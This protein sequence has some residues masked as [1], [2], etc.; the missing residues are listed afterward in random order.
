MEENR[1]KFI[2]SFVQEIGTHLVSK[3]H[4][5]MMVLGKGEGRIIGYLGSHSETVTPG[6][7]SE[8]LN[9]GSGRIANAL[10]NLET[11]KLVIRKTDSLDK[12]RTIVQLTEKGNDSFQCVKN[13]MTERIGQI[14]D[15]L[16][17]ED[18]LSLL[19]LLRKMN[20][21]QGKE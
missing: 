15:K 9:V 17:E 13:E 16:G 6:E 3:D 19:R 20:D 21:S 1:S 14:F 11:K 12:R 7:L 2:Q 4:E 18:A 10:K 8:I 5:R